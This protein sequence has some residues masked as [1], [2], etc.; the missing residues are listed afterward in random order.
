MVIL[1]RK[2]SQLTMR[3][4]NPK[5]TDCGRLLSSPISTQRWDLS[6][7]NPAKVNGI[8]PAAGCHLHRNSPQHLPRVLLRALSNEAHPYRCLACEPDVEANL[9]N[10]AF[11][12][13]E[14]QETKVPEEAIKQKII[15]NLRVQYQAEADKKAREEVERE[16]KERA[17]TAAKKQ[18]LKQLEAKR[19]GLRWKRL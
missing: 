15:R 3:F 7:T 1:T 10:E 9:L 19:P 5:F 16:G 13:L 14:D 17:T 18:E 8:R 6:D 4:S 11:K 12:Q 2:N